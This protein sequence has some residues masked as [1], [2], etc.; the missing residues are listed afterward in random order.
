MGRAC[1][2]SR[3]DEGRTP[4]P[5]S[6]TRRRRDPLTNHDE[7]PGC[8]GKLWMSF[9]GFGFWHGAPKKGTVG[10]RRS[11]IAWC[12]PGDPVPHAQGELMNSII[13]IVGVVVII[14]VILWFFGLR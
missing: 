7:A 2:W 8:G 10:M 3:R 11:C 5:V 13:Y 14:L 4:N 9:L 6:P 1:L 12:T